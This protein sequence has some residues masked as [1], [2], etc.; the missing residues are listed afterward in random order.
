[1]VAWVEESK[2]QTIGQL[3]RVGPYKNVGSLKPFGGIQFM[4]HCHE[5]LTQL[6]K[7]GCRR[8]GAGCVEG[9]MIGD[10]ALVC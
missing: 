4:V 1:M 3:R 7:P 2:K 9:V 6:R 8:V 10:N 5:K